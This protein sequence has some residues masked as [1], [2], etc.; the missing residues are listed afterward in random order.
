MGNRYTLNLS[1]AKYGETN[2]DVWFAPS[3][4]FD[5]FKCEYCGTVNRIIMCFSSVIDGKEETD[6]D[7]FG[8]IL[9]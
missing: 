3:S 5:T 4:G 7:E 9:I 6:Y 8:P 1:C 2:T